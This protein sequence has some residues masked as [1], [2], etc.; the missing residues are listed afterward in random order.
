MEQ[1]FWIS[2]EDLLRKY[3]HFE[4]T[5]LFGREWAVTQQWTTLSVPWSADYHS[6]KFMITVTE[7]SPLVIVLS[8]VTPF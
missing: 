7:E 2:Y 5:R 1:V 3:Q 4:R 6:T 8:Q